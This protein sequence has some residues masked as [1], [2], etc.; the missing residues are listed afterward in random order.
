[1]KKSEMVLDAK[2]VNI[3]VPSDL[4]KKFSGLVSVYNVL[5]QKKI[6]SKKMFLIEVIKDFCEEYEKKEI[7]LNKRK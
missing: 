5:N 7:E 2:N 1:M 3:P 6:S 4:W